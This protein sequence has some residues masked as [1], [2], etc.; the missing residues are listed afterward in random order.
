M[1]TML[2]KTN[3]TCEGGQHSRLTLPLDAPAAE[4]ARSPLSSLPSESSSSPYLS[5]PLLPSLSLSLSM[6]PSGS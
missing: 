4:L 6:A 5:P 1:I 2:N 3:D